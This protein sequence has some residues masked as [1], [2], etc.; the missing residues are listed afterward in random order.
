MIKS[1]ISTAQYWL[2]KHPKINNFEWIEGETL[3]AT[4][5]FLFSTI[6]TYL[7]ITFML[8]NLHLPPIKPKFLKP[9]SA[10]HN[11]VLLLM[12]LTM[13]LGCALSLWEHFPNINYMI[14]FPKGT[15]PKGPLFFWAYIF[16]LSK[17]VEYID[18][19]LIIVSNS[20]KRRLSFLHVYHHTMAVA[21]C[22]FSLHTS[23]SMFSSVLITN[24]LVHVL[25]YAYYFCCSI[26]IRPRWK[27]LVTDCQLLQ[28]WSSFLIMGV[29]CYS[30][31][32]GPG[33]SGMWGW[34]FNAFFITSLLVL[35]LDFHNKN[36]SSSDKIKA[37][38]MKKIKQGS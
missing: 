4:P 32:T 16:Y 14:C 11:I 28:F 20:T 25:M 7:S 1:I 30:H 36:Y 35:F 37:N 19:I 12:S 38:Q 31:F 27:R 22:F 18:T 13:A 23:Q 15:P 29:I 17:M 5:E 33:C 3:G 34:C 2:V 21:M 26:G 10:S 8:Y 9:F 24:S 6:V